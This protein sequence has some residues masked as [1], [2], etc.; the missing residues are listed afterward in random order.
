MGNDRAMLKVFRAELSADAFRELTG[1]SDV[2]YQNEQAA[3]LRRSLP[4]AEQTISATT[5][6]SLSKCFIPS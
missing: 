3:F 6:G 4:P 1:M 5:D 2:E